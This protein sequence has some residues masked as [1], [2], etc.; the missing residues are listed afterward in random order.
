MDL[1]EALRSTGAARTFR[2]EP[3]PPEVVHR[4][5]DTARFAPNGGNQQAWHVI[6][7]EDAE[8]RRA[9]RDI[10][11]DRWQQY[12]ALRGAGLRP[13]APITDRAAEAA[14]VEQAIAAR[15]T[16]GDLGDFA[17]HFDE[18]PV[19]LVLL[20]DLRLLAAM[21]RD[22]DRYTMVGGASIYP[23]A[24]NLLLAARSEGL[25]GVITTVAIGS[26]AEV[27]ALLGVPDSH[28]VA[29]VIALGHPVKQ[30]TRLRRDPVE[31]FTTVDTF[32]GPA[33]GPVPS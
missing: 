17:E 9:L 23:F 27:K 33:F 11:L 12:V 28:A 16:R 14:V 10:Y 29:A 32:D 1:I 24:W 5:L 6:V 13:W 18:V 20:A 25:G 19:L 26:E 2:D 22:L 7:L 4:L 21:D 3:V 15:E 31:D 30:P 8:R